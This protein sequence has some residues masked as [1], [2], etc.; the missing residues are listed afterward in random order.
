MEGVR[1]HPCGGLIT[2]FSSSGRTDWTNAWL[3]S[4]VLGIRLNC[5][6]IATRSLSS[7]G[8]MTGAKQSLEL[9]LWGSRLPRTTMRY[10]A[11]L[12]LPFS[13][14]FTLEIAIVGRALP[15]TGRRALYSSSEMYSHVC[16]SS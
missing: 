6:A 10:L 4:P 2:Y 5:V 8:E 15:T 7:M 11:L 16:V 14:V 12:D 13:S 3:T 1:G 9:Q